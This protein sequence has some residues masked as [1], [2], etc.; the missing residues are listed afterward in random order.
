MT[1]FRGQASLAKMMPLRGKM[2]AP[3]WPLAEKV[4]VKKAEEQTRLSTNMGQ[5]FTI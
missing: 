3:A 2:T 4:K 5:D 1:S